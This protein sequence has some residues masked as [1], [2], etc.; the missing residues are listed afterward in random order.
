MISDP[1]GF[2]LF[3]LRFNKLRKSLRCILHVCLNSRIAEDH[4]AFQHSVIRTCFGSFRRLNTYRGDHATL[5]LCHSNII[6]TKLDDPTVD[7]KRKICA[8]RSTLRNRNS[9]NS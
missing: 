3:I 2:L 5:W 9:W 7:G 6:N 1:R 4:D 8:C